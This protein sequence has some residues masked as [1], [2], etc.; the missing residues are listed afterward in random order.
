MRSGLQTAATAVVMVLT[1]AGASGCAG[2]KKPDAGRAEPLTS[3][4]MYRRGIEFLSERKLRQATNVFEQIEYSPDSRR[5]LEPLARLAVAD[6]TFYQGTDLSL[7]DARSLYL[8]FV[9]LYGDHPLAPYAQTQVGLCSLKQVNQSS[10]DQSQTHRAI[11]DFREVIDRYPESIYSDAARTLLELA[12][13][14]LAQSEYLIGRFYL[15][16]KAFNAAAERFRIVTDRYPDY[17]EKDKVLFHL[18]RALHLGGNDSE[19]R[20]Y[21]DKLLAD[22]PEGTYVDEARRSLARL[23][24][25]LALDVNGLQD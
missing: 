3:H 12:H 9:T 22:Y 21:L 10:K 11:R 15:K 16:R 2:K 23:G 24:G 18:S 17:P 20:I 13:S 14:N 7:I 19:A 5:E 4:G 6:A 8:D 1:L 25:T